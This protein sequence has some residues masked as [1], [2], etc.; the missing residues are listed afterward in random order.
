MAGIEF[1]GIFLALVGLAVC[2]LTGGVATLGC[3]V[4]RKAARLVLDRVVA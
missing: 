4:G 1:S 3:F 2:A